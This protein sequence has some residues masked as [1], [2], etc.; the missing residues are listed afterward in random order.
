[1]TEATAGQLMMVSDQ[2]SLEKTQPVFKCTMNMNAE[3]NSGNSSFD[4]QITTRYT[5]LY[6]QY[7]KK[8][9]FFQ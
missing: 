7:I 9:R 6:H 1:M 4:S 8:H 3:N 5:V 2:F